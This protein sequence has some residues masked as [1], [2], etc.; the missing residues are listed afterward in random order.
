MQ[1]PDQPP[2]E[3][4]PDRREQVAERTR[5][6]RGLGIPSAVATLGVFTGLAAVSQHGADTS[7]A[8]H[9]VVDNPSASDDV[10]QS[11]Q[12]VDS[13][14]AAAQNGFFDS[15]GGG[16]VSAASSGTGAS[17]MSGAS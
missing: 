8:S 7:S 15:P 11:T 10:S 9:V 17:V 13:D 5:H 4:P 1:K 16:S 6:L 2:A 3:R 14:D 12:S